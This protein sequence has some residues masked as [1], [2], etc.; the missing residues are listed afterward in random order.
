MGTHYKGTHKEINVLNSF[1]KL[2]RV[3]EKLSSHLYMLFEKEG[4]TESQFY[5]LDV[6][7]HLGQMS[8]K[9]LGKKISR[10]EGNITMVVNNLLRRKLIKKKQNENDKRIYLITLTSEGKNLYEKVFPKFLKAIM[11]EFEGVN[12]KEHEEFQK[13]CKR[14]GKKPIPALPNLSRLWHAK[15][16]GKGF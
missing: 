4:L 9:E 3:Y 7:Y 13:I 8:Q 10:S 5:A 12:E 15:A 1:I 6:L 16:E 14:I 11:N 2:I